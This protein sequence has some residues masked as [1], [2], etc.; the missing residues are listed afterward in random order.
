MIRKFLNLFRKAKVYS[1]KDFESQI[2]K[3]ANGATY[4]IGIL[5]WYYA[6]DE[7]GGHRPAEFTLWMDNGIKHISGKTP[8]EVINKLKIKLDEMTQKVNI[9]DIE[10]E[11]KDDILKSHGDI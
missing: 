6:H 11:I 2:D 4:Q 5:K 1:F 10:I 7:D 3:L 9:K 8:Q